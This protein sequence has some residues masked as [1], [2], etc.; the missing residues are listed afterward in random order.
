[1]LLVG[2]AA[3]GSSFVV[4][5]CGWPFDDDRPPECPTVS[6]APVDETC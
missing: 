4:G 5:A 3:L 2:L 6:D 1:V